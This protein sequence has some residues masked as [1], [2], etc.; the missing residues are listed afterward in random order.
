MNRLVLTAYRDGVVQTVTNLT[1]AEALRFATYYPGGLYGDASFYLPSNVTDGLGLTY[2]DKIVITN[3]LVTVYEGYVTSPGISIDAARSGRRVALTGAWGNILMARKWRKPWRDLRIDNN[4]WVYD[5]TRTGAEKCTLDRQNRIRFTPKAVAWATG[6]NARVQYTA[7]TGETIKRVVFNYDLQEG[8]QNWTITLWDITNTNNEWTVS[9]S[10]TGSADITITAPTTCA[11]IAFQFAAGA[12]QTPASDG[13][14]YAQVSGLEVLTETGAISPRNIA[15]D[16]ALKVTEISADVSLI[17]ANSLNITSF[18]SDVDTYADILTNA[19]SMGDSS[20]NPWAAGV[21]ASSL[22]SDGKPILFLEQQ[23]ALTDYDYAVRLND[24]NLVAPFEA[25]P[26]V[27][28]VRNWIAVQ[29]RTAEGRPVWITPDDD[30]NLTNAASRTAYGRREEWLT[31]QTESSTTAT[32]YGRR[33]LAARKDV[34][35]TLTGGISVVGYI[36]GKAGQLIPASEIQAGK[37]VRIENYLND[38]NGTGLTM[39]I[40]ATD[41]DDTSQVCTISAGQPNSLETWLARTMK[42]IDRNRT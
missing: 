25:E 28:D 16:V 27:T 38:L 3:G 2:N 20:Y 18:V 4:V 17:S 1:R 37:R 19:Y 30:A 26:N 15:E 14:I 36:R 31:L 8:A 5:T 22:S 35:W 24:P 34:Q 21:R 12:N 41:Y 13:T 42:Q 9:T 33:F 39:L 7:P 29:Y 10:G 32:Q 23:P 40:T 11:V 6:E